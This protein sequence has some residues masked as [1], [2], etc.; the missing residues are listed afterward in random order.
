MRISHRHKFVFASNPKTGSESIRL[1]L[2]PLSDIRDTPFHQ[3]T[4][5]RPFYSHIR[6]IE[7]RS[8]FRRFGWRYED[9]YSFVFIRNPW[10]R[11]VSLYRYMQ[12]TDL[13]GS[14]DFATWL[15]QS[16]TDGP[17]GGGPDSARWL[18][19]GTYTIDA[20]AGDGEGNLLVNDVFRLEDIAEVP[21]RLRARGIPIAE[22]AEAPWKNR[23]PESADLSTY[24]TRELIEL[25]A[26][27]YA[28]EIE[29]FDYA[30]PEVGSV[31]PERHE[32]V[33]GY[34]LRPQAS[35]AA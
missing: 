18:K 21:E 14:A 22:G 13:R 7:I 31:A 11:L 6:P 32:R 19:Y 4:P 10:T 3:A 25:V 16:R 28:T 15:K 2:D 27:R 35:D 23:R 24:Y 26:Q 9:Y 1:L 8:A 17:G 12:K 20:Y 5:L 34:P 33:H 29:K 30:Y